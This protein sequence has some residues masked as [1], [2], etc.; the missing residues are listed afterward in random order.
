ME[1]IISISQIILGLLIIFLVA[2]Q[3]KEGGL[4]NIFGGNNLTTYSTRRG[5]EKTLFVLTIVSISLFI[6]LSIII[7]RV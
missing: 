2:I 3:P 1:T 4:S 7:F 5:L 6:I